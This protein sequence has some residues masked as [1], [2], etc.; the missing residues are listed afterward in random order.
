MKPD[1]YQNPL[2]MHLRM[3]LCR[4]Y[5]DFWA[6]I[7]LHAVRNRPSVFTH[8]ISLMNCNNLVT[9]ASDLQSLNAY[10]AILRDAFSV[11]SLIA[12]AVL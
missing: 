5:L 2:Q 10:S 7:V 6:A 4:L 11:I 3:I 1:F 9:F 12:T 8:D